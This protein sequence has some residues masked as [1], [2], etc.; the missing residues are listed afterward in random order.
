MSVLNVVL[1]GLAAIGGM[2]GIAA[3]VK[4]FFDR[5]QIRADAVDQ[6]ADTSVKMLT[7][8]HAEIDRLSAKLRSAEQEV[9]DLR[10]QM[11]T[12][13]EHSDQLTKVQGKLRDAEQESDTLR[14]QVRGLYEQLEEKDRALAHKDREIAR[15]KTDGGGS[16]GTA[17]R[18]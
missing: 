17:T 11:R 2:S 8:L 4:V 18:P 6:I 16:G 10:R 7:P 9:D 12:M 13:A 3:L 5:T 14:R 1:T 15:L